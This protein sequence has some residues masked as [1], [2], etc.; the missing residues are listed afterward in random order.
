MEPTVQE[1]E[2]IDGDVRTEVFATVGTQD[3]RESVRLLGAMPAPDFELLVKGVT[4]GGQAL[5]P[6]AYHGCI[7]A[8]RAARLAS[9]AEPTSAGLAAQAASGAAAVQ[10]AVTGAKEAAEAAR[11]AADA[12]A[13]AVTAGGPPNG[14]ELS[15]VTN[16]TAR[17]RVEVLTAP[18]EKQFFETYKKIFGQRGPTRGKELS[19]EQIAGFAHL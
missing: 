19:S 5:R 3:G 17:G 13:G 10:Q 6:L 8:G 1:L 7:L 9:G 11:R 12:L 2:S 14:V 15:L 4:I 18:E 16:Q